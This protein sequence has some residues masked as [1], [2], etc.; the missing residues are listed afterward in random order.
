MDEYMK[1]TQN[2]GLYIIRALSRLLFL[3]LLLLLM[4]NVDLKRGRI[5]QQ[6]PFILGLPFIFI[7]SCN[8]DN[9]NFKKILPH[10]TG[11]KLRLKEVF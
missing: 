8:P 10:F 2:S 6:L 4:K 9:N 7:T 11:E 3:L 5:L 1:S